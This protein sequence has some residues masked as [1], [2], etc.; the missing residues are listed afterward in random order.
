M[1]EM[2]DAASP[3]RKTED[4][5]SRYVRLWRWVVVIMT[6]VSFT[7]LIILTFLNY[8]QY[9]NAIREEIKERVNHITGMTKHSIEFF[10]AERAAALVLITNERSY[11]ELKDQGELQVVFAHLKNALGGMVDLSVID[12]DGKQVSYVGPYARELAGKDY[13]EQ[14]WFNK[15][16]VQGHY[17]SDVYMGYR[18][19]PHFVIALSASDKD[20]RSYVLRATIDSSTLDELLRSVNVAPP[21]ELFIINHEGILQTPSNRH[22][23]LLG[24]ANIPTPPYVDHAVVSQIKDPQG[25]ELIQ[26]HAYI[27]NSPF[28]LMVLKDPSAAGKNWFALA[29]NLWLIL[30]FSMV[31]ILLIVMWISYYLVSRIRLADEQRTQALHKIEYTNKM[32]SIGRLAAGVAHEINNPLAIINEKAGM[33]MDMIGIIE[34]FPEKE[35]VSKL[36]EA[37]QNSV[38]RC[39][40]ITRRLLRFAKHI[41][42]QIESIDLE[43]LAREVISFLEHEAKFRKIAI[44]VIAKGEIKPIESDRGQL[45]QVFLNILNNSLNALSESNREGKIKVSIYPEDM[46]FVSIK[47]M[48][49]GPGIPDEHMKQ[50]FDPFFTTRSEGTGLGLSITYGIVQKLGG[51]IEVQSELGVGTSFTIFLP[52]GNMIGGDIK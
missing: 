32:A 28:I 16:I 1:P 24:K 42:L 7:P 3:W 47:F 34:N 20:G 51:R 31:L 8:F 23:E 48:D 10:L 39:S 18:N 44:E 43:Q 21:S 52:S 2:H 19:L 30:I 38:G 45:Q 29:R 36:M 11:D 6:L 12:P 49:N 40:R 50:I 27:D 22:G 26:G 35:K 41:D 46:G 25:L 33:M 14:E 37:I 5:Q 4:G 13:S 17:V 15:V 9:K